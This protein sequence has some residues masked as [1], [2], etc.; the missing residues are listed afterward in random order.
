MLECRPLCFTLKLCCL[1]QYGVNLRFVSVGAELL[2]F[3]AHTQLSSLITL[4]K[5]LAHHDHLVLLS[6][7]LASCLLGKVLLAA[8]LDLCLLCFGY[9]RL[10]R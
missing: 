10:L 5:W 4:T 6:L 2:I 9:I 7:T 3:D 8:S 1:I